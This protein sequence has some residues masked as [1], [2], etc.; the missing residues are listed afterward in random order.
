MERFKE[1]ARGIIGGKPKE[2][3]I[4]NREYEMPLDI[5]NAYKSLKQAVSK[6]A[7]VH[8]STS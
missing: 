3:V 4:V 1:Y 8:G 6:P 7:T 5:V 2:G